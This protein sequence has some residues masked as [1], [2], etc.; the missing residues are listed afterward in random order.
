MIG[1]KRYHERTPASARGESRTQTEDE[2]EVDA[3]RRAPPLHCRSRLTWAIAHA[4]GSLLLL[5]ACSKHVDRG[6]ANST[7]PRLPASIMADAASKPPIELSAPALWQAYE[8]DQ[9]AAIHAY[10]GKRLLITGT[11]GAISKNEFDNIV[12]QLSTPN[13]TQAV[14]AT[15]Q[16]SSEKDKAASLSRGQSVSVRCIG[17]T[18]LSAGPILSH[19][20]LEG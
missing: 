9:A 12:I 4:V 18:K 16:S 20:S 19:C 7:L 1:K 8:A 6:D 10:Q 14:H 2:L 13:A 11:V 17:G 5:S 15:V 3:P